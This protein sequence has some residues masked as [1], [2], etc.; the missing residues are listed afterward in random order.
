MPITKERLEN[1]DVSLILKLHC[2]F[3]PSE[4]WRPSIP[5]TPHTWEP[6][7]LGTPIPV[8]GPPIP[9]RSIFLGTL[10]HHTF[11]NGRAPVFCICFDFSSPF[12]S[13]CVNKPPDF[14]SKPTEKEVCW[15]PPI[16][17]GTSYTV[18]GDSLNNGSAYTSPNLAVVVGTFYSSNHSNHRNHPNHLPRTP[19]K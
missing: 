6:P 2:Y 10:S 19:P 14:N 18:P 7:Y 11:L 4:T 9:W 3:K 8:G 12:F 5:G 16:P 17:G 13:T 1:M 15:G